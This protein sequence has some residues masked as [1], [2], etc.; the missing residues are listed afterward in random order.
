MH[1]IHSSRQQD[2]NVWQKRRGILSL[3]HNPQVK[4]EQLEQEEHA[5]DGGS[6]EG[7]KEG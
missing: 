2:L 1:L 6:E 7:E 5:I 4:V 3:D